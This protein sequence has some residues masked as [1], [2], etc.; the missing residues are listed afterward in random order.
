MGA[1]G[2][3]DGAVDVVPADVPVDV[4]DLDDDAMLD[5]LGCPPWADF[6]GADG[7][8]LGVNGGHGLRRE[9]LRGGI[10][11]P[12]GS[13]AACGNTDHEA[14]DFL[15]TGVCDLRRSP[16]GGNGRIDSPT[17]LSVLLLVDVLG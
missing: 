4:L 5:V 3:G 8:G 15:A 9:E 7:W 16:C 17:S 2:G 13:L 1:D 10:A 11:C 6:L 14:F 12:A